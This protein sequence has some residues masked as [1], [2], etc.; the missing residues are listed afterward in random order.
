[1]RPVSYVC[2]H[3]KGADFVHE[4]KRNLVVRP[5]VAC[6]NDGFDIPANVIIA[7]DLYL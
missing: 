7:L 5:F 6:P 1:M 2:C 4:L 3:T